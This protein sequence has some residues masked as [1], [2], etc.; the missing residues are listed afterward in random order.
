ME[1]IRNVD[2][3]LKGMYFGASNI[4]VIRAL[5]QGPEFRTSTP[6]EKPGEVRDL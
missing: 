6:C 3:Y 4:V 1:Q 5:T 2:V